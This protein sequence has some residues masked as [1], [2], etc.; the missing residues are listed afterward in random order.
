MK[1]EPLKKIYTIAIGFDGTIT[2]KDIRP[3]IGHL[4]PHI[5]EVIDFLMLIGVKVIIT[6]SRENTKDNKDI[7][8]MIAYLTKNDIKYSSIITSFNYNGM[9]VNNSI[10][11]DM[12]VNNKDFG[13]HRY[14]EDYVMLQV[15]H[16]FLVNV[17]HI[18]CLLAESINFNIENHDKIKENVIAYCRGIVKYGPDL[19]DPLVEACY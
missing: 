15:L 3:K 12:Y 8:D 14:P 11:A 5:K 4:R 13:F 10:S 6:S 7:D 1:R 9:K 17:V 19:S 16:D 2:A 18:P